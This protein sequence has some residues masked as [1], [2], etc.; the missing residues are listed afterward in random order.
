LFFSVCYGKANFGP[1][2]LG[3]S[4]T[5]TVGDGYYEIDGVAQSFY[6]REKPMTLP[7]FP[8]VPIV[9]STRRICI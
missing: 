2:G 9:Q 7:E 5:S 8:I 3:G 4:P 1:S 6:S